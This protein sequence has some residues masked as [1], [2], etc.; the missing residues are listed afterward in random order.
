MVWLHRH[1]PPVKYGIHTTL[2]HIY[3]IHAI[4]LD[5]RSDHIRNTHMCTY[6]PHCLCFRMF[7]R[8]LVFQFAVT[9]Q[10]VF[11]MVHL[12]SIF[13]QCMF[14]DYF[15]YFS[16][17]HH[18]LLNI[19]NCV[20]TY[21]FLFPQSLNSKQPSKVRFYLKRYYHIYSSL[22]GTFLIYYSHYIIHYKKEGILLFQI[23]L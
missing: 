2:S 18:E 9:T 10:I 13:F 4:A 5:V 1:A 20:S 11:R 21:F 14:F 8:W 6:L 3:Y 16:P 12:I 15:L 22:Q 19:F 7:L 23:L 17:L